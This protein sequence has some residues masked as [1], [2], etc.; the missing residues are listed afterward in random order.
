MRS[1]CRSHFEEDNDIIFLDYQD[2]LRCSCSRFML[3]HPVFKLLDNDKDVAA[4]D[5]QDRYFITCSYKGHFI[6]VCNFE[7]AK[8][9][10][11]ILGHAPHCSGC[12]N[13][14]ETDL[15]FLYKKQTLQD[16]LDDIAKHTEEEE[17]MRFMNWFLK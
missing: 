1:F 4:S 13:Y 12:M 5:W 16:V 3:K 15:S 7:L 2:I 17:S 10:Y 6:K 14:V 8:K 11:L 9:V